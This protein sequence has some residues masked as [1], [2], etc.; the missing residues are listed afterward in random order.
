M[1]VGGE[2]SAEPAA[3]LLASVDAALAVPVHEEHGGEESDADGDAADEHGPQ[4]QVE[5]EPR[6]RPTP[7]AMQKAGSEI[8]VR[9]DRTEMPDRNW[10]RDAEMR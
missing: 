6:W 2:R 5:V 8:G 9:R 1:T 3:R 10:S 7:T 4:R